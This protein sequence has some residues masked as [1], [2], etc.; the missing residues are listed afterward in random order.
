MTRQ[1]PPYSKSRGYRII[2]TAFGLFFIG[3][4]L[5]AIGYTI[6]DLILRA[7]AGSGVI[8]ISI[9]LGIGLCFG[10]YQLIVAA[11]EGRESWLAKLG[12]LP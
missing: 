10:G 2:S 8:A 4:G 7:P 12:P 6:Q 11:R 5:V 3:L 1:S 9:V